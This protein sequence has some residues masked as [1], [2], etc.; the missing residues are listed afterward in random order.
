[1]L[2][3]L[4][5]AVILIVFVGRKVKSINAGDLVLVTGGV[6][7]GKSTFAVWYVLARYRSALFKWKVGNFVHKCFTAALPKAKPFREKPLLYSNI[8][9]HCDYVPLTTEL[10]RRQKRFAYGSC[11]YCGEVSLVADSMMYK[12]VVL[13]EELTLF[14][15]LIGHELRGFG[16]CIVYDTQAISDCHYSVKRTVS[17]YFYIHHLVKWIPFI[18]IAHVVEERYSDDNSLVSVDTEDVSEKL[19][20]V[21]IPK[22]VWK[23][24][25]S[26]CYS[27][28]TDDLEVENTIVNGKTLPDLKARFIVSFRKWKNA[29]LRGETNEKEA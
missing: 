21:V 20:W 25:D 28:L 23:M 8:P 19:K 1:M 3:V 26:H 6:K 7:C 5:I 11:I 29:M 27:V 24:F 17:N 16:G 10:L 9:L 4:I 22:S 13:N 18:I 12:D 15:K 2:L 14:N